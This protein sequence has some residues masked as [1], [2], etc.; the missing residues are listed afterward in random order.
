MTFA[1]KSYPEFSA[2]GAEVEVLVVATVFVE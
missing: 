1:P 2:E